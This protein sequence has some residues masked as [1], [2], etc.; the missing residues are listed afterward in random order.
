MPIFFENFRLFSSEKTYVVLKSSLV[1]NHPCFLTVK[2]RSK[3]L[4]GLVRVGMFSQS[5]CL[6]KKH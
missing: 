5:E 6:L 2:Q 4:R 3:E 1:L